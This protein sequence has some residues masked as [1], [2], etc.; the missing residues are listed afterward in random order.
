MG[1]KRA[2][3]VASEVLEISLK[4]I[5]FEAVSKLIKP[6]EGEKAYIFMNKKEGKLMIE[7]PVFEN[8]NEGIR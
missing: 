3:E 1:K 7:F 6:H 4:K 8:Q 2:E 5:H